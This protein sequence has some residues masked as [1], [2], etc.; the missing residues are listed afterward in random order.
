VSGK[1]FIRGLVPA[2]CA[3]VLLLVGLT[4]PTACRGRRALTRPAA[5][6]D[7]AVRPERLT[8]RF[9]KL[10]RAHFRGVARF[11]VGVEDAALKGVTTETDVWID[12]R[13]NWRLVELN[14]KDGGRE[15]VRHDRELAVA[16][17]YGKMIRRPA[18]DPE[19]QRLLEEGLGAPFAAWDLLRDLTTVDDMGSENRAG[20]KAHVYR[21]SKA[22]HPARPSRTVDPGDRRAWRRTV[23][24][25]SIE[26]TVVIDDATGL[27]L[28]TEIRAKYAMRRGDGKSTDAKAGTLMH[29]AIDVRTSIEE[30]GQ[31]PT[32]ARPEAEDP[33]LRQRT[34]PEEKALLGG[35]PRS[36]P[37][38]PAPP[39]R[40]LE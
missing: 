26:G 22:R 16:L 25:E 40:G 32:I 14:D 17:R 27:A 12:D 4:G 24:P 28:R 20:R 33:P 30:I 38:V 39:V 8:T 9:R 18:E 5:A 7:A 31:S 2:P 37:P 11:E 36:P 3:L 29:G 35:L 34:V 1:L 10:G 6:V 21:L 13:G 23:V 19:P 15:I